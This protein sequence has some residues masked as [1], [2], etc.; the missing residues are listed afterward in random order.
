MKSKMYAGIDVSAASF[1]AARQKDRGRIEHRS[2]ANDS[3]G[4]R[5][6]AGW[7]GRKGRVCMEATGVYHLALALA[8]VKAGIEVMVVNP[9]VAHDFAGA[10]S[11]RIKT[12]KVDALVL[13]EFVQRMPF[14]LWVPPRKAVMELRAL[15]R[16][17][18]ELIGTATAE[19][20]RLHAERV[21]GS[22][23]YVER[24][25][26]L[27][28][29]Q[30]S[31]RVKGLGKEA[32]AVIASDE[33]LSAQYKRLVAMVGIGP[34]TASALLGEL[35]VLD[36]TMGVRQVVAHAGLDPRKKQSGTSIDT[37][38]RIS[39]V[40]NARIRG[41]LYLV[42]VTAIRCDPRAKAFYDKLV[43]RGKA[44]M[45]ALVAV[46]RKLLHGVWMVMTRGVEFDSAKLFPTLLVAVADEQPV[47]EA[48][49]EQPVPAEQPVSI[50]QNSS[51]GRSRR[52]PSAVAPQ[53]TP[54]RRAARSSRVVGGAT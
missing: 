20:N 53:T 47:S 4:H 49:V 43:G 18:A 42:A 25:I 27:H 41:T 28:L 7:I 33:E 44:K 3:K 17:R 6:A 32:L 54:V 15:T 35:A 26:R 39:K 11:K 46:M 8:L 29:E 5:E 52:A 9:R 10:L 30:L 40:G 31:K 23:G 2:F 50:G 1:E 14:M 16:R 21:S 19:K 36:P 37:P 34:T 22:N 48:E 12:D 24:D 45:Q 13:L 51:R 38:T